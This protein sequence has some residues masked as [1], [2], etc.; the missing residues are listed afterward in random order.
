[1]CFN[2]ASKVYNERKVDMAGASFTKDRLAKIALELNQLP[3]LILNAESPHFHFRR[4]FDSD[5]RRNK[6]SL[7]SACLRL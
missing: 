7:V 2:L 1:M 6:R 5:S 3:Y 4:L